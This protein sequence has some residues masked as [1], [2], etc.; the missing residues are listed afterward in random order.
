MGAVLGVDA[1]WTEHKPSGIALIEKVGAIWLLKAATASLPDFAR[2]CGLEAPRRV[3]L[4]FAIDCA[5]RLLG[6]RLPDLVAVDMPLSHAPIV[7]RRLSDIGISKRFGAAKCSTH[8]PS[9]ARPGKVSDRLHEDC[10]A[11]GYRLRTAASPPHSLALAEVYPHPALLRLMAVEERVKYKVGKTTTYWRG[12]AAEERLLNVREELEKIARRLDDVVAGAL[13]AVD[14]ETPASF[15]ALKPVEDTI[16]A[17]VAAWIGATILEGDAEAFGD[18]ESA[19]WVPR[20]TW[21]MVH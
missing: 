1:A 18:E 17:I 20:E 3:G 2:R 12:A 14:I 10:K 21:A 6:G 5:R 4:S 16:D 11:R 15:S 9:A 19:I 8:S 7:G 13:D